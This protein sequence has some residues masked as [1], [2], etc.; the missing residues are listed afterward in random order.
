MQCETVPPG[1]EIVVPR[2]HEAL[3]Q[4]ERIRR[5]LPSSGLDLF[6][7]FAPVSIIHV[8]SLDAS[9]RPS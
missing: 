1:W 9:S 8:S 7:D 2:V 6:A 5:L 4:L 3:Q